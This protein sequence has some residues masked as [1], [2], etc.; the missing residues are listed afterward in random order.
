MQKAFAKDYV[1]NWS[2]EAFVIQKVTKTVL[3]TYRISDLIEKKLLESFTK[4]ICK[5]QTI[6]SLEMQK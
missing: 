1:P 4:N 3:W 5:K 6:K 2:K